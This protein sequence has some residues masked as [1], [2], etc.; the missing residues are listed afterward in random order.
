MHDN[1][2]EDELVETRRKYDHGT[3]GKI[4]SFDETQEKWEAYVERAEQFFLA[5]NIDED[6][7]VPTYFVKVDRRQNVRLVQRSSDIRKTSYEELPGDRHNPSTLK[8]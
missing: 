3:I 6:H 7:Q 2:D 4:E 5:I 1:G 8:S